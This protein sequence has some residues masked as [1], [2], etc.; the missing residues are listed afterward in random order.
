PPAGGYRIELREDHALLVQVLDS[1]GRPAPRVPMEIAR[2]AADGT[3][4]RPWSR[5]YLRN[6][7][8]D[9]TTRLFHVQEHQWDDGSEPSGSGAQWRVH[10]KIPA[11]PDPGVAFDPHALPAD[12]LVLH[13]PAT[14]SV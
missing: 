10:T 3:Y 14:G 8:Q 7:D 6:T 13:L 12:P 9:G 4:L 1:R 11:L 2:C 5:G